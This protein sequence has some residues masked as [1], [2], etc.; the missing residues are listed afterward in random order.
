MLLY[1]TA[2]DLADVFPVTKERYFFFSAC[3]R[4]INSHAF[5]A[6]SAVLSLTVQFLAEASCP[7]KLRVNVPFPTLQIIW[8][9]KV[10]PVPVELLQ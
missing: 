1:F 3:E 9:K 2:F 8:L 6:N 7:C 4:E 5:W 10:L